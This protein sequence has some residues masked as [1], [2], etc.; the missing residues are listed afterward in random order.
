MNGP[1]E[2]D[3]TFQVLRDLPVEVTME[4]VGS[5]VAVFTLAPPAASW[6]SH[7]NLN[8]ILMTSAGAI[9]IAGSIYLISPNHQE[10]RTAHANIPAPVPTVEQPATPPLVAVEDPAP[11]VLE[12]IAL[13]A[14]PVKEEPIT[15][16]VKAIP[17][18]PEL[19]PP[20][21]TPAA[22]IVVAPTPPV[23]A[24][25]PI[26]GGKE[27]DLRGFTGV[28]VK[29]AMNVFIDQG[30]FAVTAE[31]DQG[32]MDGL[33]LTVK[34]KTLVIAMKSKDGKEECASGKSATV[35]VRMPAMEQLELSGSG[36][37]MMGEFTASGNFDLGLQG[38]GDVHVSALKGLATLSIDLT[39]SGDVVGEGIE[40]AGK[41]KISI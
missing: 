29:G 10:P 8:S 2:R 34:D 6:F 37:V 30:D 28:H 9:I 12:P 13:E 41:T 19:A 17:V 7:I 40:V 31:G 38:S 16:E 5:M 21:P 11:I 3:E 4:Q 36:D 26:G 33:D 14:K 22:A 39:G 27:F 1:D 20:T 32:M 24:T 15:P 35:R 25:A 18:V 23:E